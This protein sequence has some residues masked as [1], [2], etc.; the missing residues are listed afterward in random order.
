M[1]SACNTRL[2]GA[3]VTSVVSDLL[4]M[5][6]HISISIDLCTCDYYSCIILGSTLRKA[7]CQ[8]HLL[9]AEYSLNNVASSAE[10]ICGSMTWITFTCIT[11]AV[12]RAKDI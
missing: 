1:T 2:T 10:L 4:G 6:P 8:R 3:M 7:L 5:R 11:E 9:I 12:T